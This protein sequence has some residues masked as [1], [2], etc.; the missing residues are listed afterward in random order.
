VFSCFQYGNCLGSLDGGDTTT[1]FT[2]N[3]DEDDRFGW[4]AGLEFAGNDPSV[5]Y[6]GGDRL[7]KSTDGVTFDPISPDLTG[8][9]G[10][11]PIYPF[12]T[13]T[14]VRATGTEIFA[15]TDDGRI[16]VSRDGGTTWKLSYRSPQWVTRVIIDPADP[17]HAVATLSGYR[18]GTGNGH[19]LETRDTG[20]TWTDITGA[21]PQAPV[22]S[23]VF[24]PH[25]LLIVATDAGVF[26]G[27]HRHWLR[28]G[29]LPLAPVT[30][31]KWQAATSTVVGATF[32][33]GV[34][35][36]HLGPA[37]VRR[38]GSAG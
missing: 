28:L 17:R 14:T 33:R 31:V 32:G 38:L 26:A 5:M 37:E 20:A 13:I 29:S 15:G 8:G 21:L 35:T 2:V 3:A 11:D 16:Q 22:N 19:V 24:A 12:G 25:G 10:D 1:D 30:D 18:N 9:P 36:L 27:A 34:Y 6:L 4:F 7:F 23:A